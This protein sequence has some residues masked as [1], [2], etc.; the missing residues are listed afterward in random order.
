MDRIDILTK[1]NGGDKRLFHG[2]KEPRI[3]RSLGMLHLG[4]FRNAIVDIAF[5]AA[6]MAR[7]CNFTRRIKFTSFAELNR[8]KY[9]SLRVCS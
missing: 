1:L 3:P 2:V 8:R 7:Y 4:N 6:Y 5:S 9:S